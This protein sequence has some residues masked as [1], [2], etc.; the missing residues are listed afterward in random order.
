MRVVGIDA[1]YVNFAVCAID[2]RQPSRPYYWVNEPL[3][4]GQ[5]SE[6]RLV[7]AIYDWIKKD[8][9]KEL[10][11]N[12][13]VI[14][15]ERQMAMKFQ[16]VNHCIRFLYFAKTVEYNTMTVGAYFGFPRERQK[17]KKAVV[18]LIG[19]NVSTLAKKGKKD[20]L[21]D[22]YSLAIYHAFTKNL[23]SKEGW[24]IDGVSGTQS[25]GRRK[26]ET[27]DLFVE[28]AG[29]PDSSDIYSK[30]RIIDLA[31]SSDQ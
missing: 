19:K 6:E 27:R 26:R 31:S 21:A 12:A 14:V 5:F 10:L 2:T 11:D 24:W 4:T 28:T 18:E 22:A 25:S 15:L 17:K 1:G 13:D 20:D 3:F 8:E 7:H 23:V 9:I 30:R 29:R 16:A